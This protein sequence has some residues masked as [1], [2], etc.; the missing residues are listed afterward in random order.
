MSRCRLRTAS[1]SIPASQQI[2]A[3]RAKLTS[4]RALSHAGLPR[5]HGRTRDFDSFADGG[6]GQSERHGSLPG[7]Q[8][9]G[10]DRALHEGDRSGRDARTVL[11]PLG[12]VRRHRQVGGGAQRRDQVRRDAT[13]LGQG[14]RSQGRRAARPRPVR[15]GDRRVRKGP[16]RGARAGD[17]DQGSRGRKEGGRAGQGRGWPWRPR[18]HLRRARRDLEDRI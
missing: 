11:Q 13:G 12:R 10:G 1:K 7:R 14:L 9:R 5:Q 6:R 17:A 8:V 16:H 3:R 4:A 2:V 15:R 18:Q